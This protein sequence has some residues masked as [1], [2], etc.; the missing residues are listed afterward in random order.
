[1]AAAATVL[2]LDLGDAFTKAIVTGGARWR[3]PSVVAHRLIS[4]P[5]DM[6]DLSLGP[7]RA[8][9]RP[10][11]FDARNYPRTRSYRGAD[12]FVQRVRTEARIPGA[13]FA[14]GIAAVYGAGRQTLGDH[15]AVE[16]V[17]ALVH[18]ALIATS[19]D[20]SLLA[21]LVLVVDIGAKADAILRWAATPRR[22]FAIDVCNYRGEGSR[23]L[24]VSVECEVVDAA[25][26]AAI[27]LPTELA[28]TNGRRTLVIDIGHL[29]TKIAIVSEEGCELQLELPELGL[30]GCVRRIL[31]DCQEH[32][33]FEDEYAVM[34][35]LEEGADV[36]D[37]AGRRFDVKVPF[38][39]AVSELEQELGRAIRR[40]VVEHFR[41]RGDSCHAVAVIGGGAAI[42]GARLAGR[43]QR[44]LQL[45]STWVAKAAD[46]HV[47]EGAR[48]L[49][50]PG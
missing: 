49:G 15:P 32:G 37:V 18:K 3:F 2:F 38:E 5:A 33:L 13:R 36:I 46:F 44:D 26:C 29:R 23:S 11:G 47:V 8:V 27:A 12:G 28:P 14:G 4:E 20:D 21:K 19:V 31:R 1:M 16:N 30:E 39:H 7:S 34:R 48:R 24:D 6:A 50:W 22:Q 25:R 43:V 17:D 9:S 41:S 10:V 40:A 42:A 35:A 45:A